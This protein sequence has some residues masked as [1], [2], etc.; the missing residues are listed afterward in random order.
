MR[1][2][3]PQDVQAVLAGDLDGLDLVAL[4]ELV[5]EVL[6]LSGDARGDDGALALEEVGGRSARGHHAFFPLGIA[7]DGHTDV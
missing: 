4:G 5:R 7:L 6:E 3:V 1:G 2:G